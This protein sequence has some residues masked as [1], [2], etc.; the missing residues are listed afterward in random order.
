MLYPVIG[1]YARLYFGRPIIAVKCMTIH[2][3]CVVMQSAL[4]HYICISKGKVY[5]VWGLP[6]P[7]ML[8]R[9]GGVVRR[10][11][12]GIICDGL[13]D[14]SF[15]I[16]QRFKTSNFKKSKLEN[17]K[18]ESGPFPGSEHLARCAPG[19]YGG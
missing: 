3:L 1:F 8:L 16:N 11:G 2:Y 15:S 5:Q 6:P 7:L 4:M 13:T 14:V 19:G 10:G 9:G 17:Q 12:G 18:I